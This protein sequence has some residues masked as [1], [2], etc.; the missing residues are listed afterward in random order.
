M[1]MI[2]YGIQKRECVHK[3]CVMFINYWQIKS[4]I[5]GNLKWLVYEKGKVSLFNARI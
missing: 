3:I 5:L 2:T 4:T 1:E